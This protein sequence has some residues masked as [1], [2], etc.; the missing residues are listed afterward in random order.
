[1]RYVGDLITECQRDT[2]NKGSSS[3]SGVDPEDFLRYLNYG[4]DRI[5]ALLLNKSPQL[6]QRQEILN[7]VANQEEYSLTGNLYL[8]C[9]IVNVEYSSSGNDRD[10][11]KLYE[12]G[13]YSR[14]TYPQGYPRNYIRRN[15]SI[16]VVPT[17][18]QSQGTLR[19]IFERAVDRLDVVRAVV[20]GTPS[21]AVIATTSADISA[22]PTNIS[23]ARYICISD[24]D[25]V[26]LLRNGLVSSWSSPNLTLAANVSTY[27][28]TGYTLADLAGKNITVYKNST[29]VSELDNACESYLQAYCNWM[30]LGRDA[31]TKEKALAFQTAWQAKE[32][33]LLESYS[34]PDKDDDE[35]QISN[36]SLILP[37]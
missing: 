10:Y 6:F 37:Q 35:I 5:F 3:V 8:G 7:L 29:T 9:R 18:S 32:A 20:N 1:M 15:G 25:G 21:G 28:T 36:E 12:Q 26:V 31:A 19:V 27:L 23:N 30:V 22:S 33:E 24:D 17:P 14:D 13:Y 11:F 16:L 34:L 4:Q 2:N